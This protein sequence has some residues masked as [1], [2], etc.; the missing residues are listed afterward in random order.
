MTEIAEQPKRRGRKPKGDR[1]MTN[2]ERVAASRFRRRYPDKG[3]SGKQLSVMLSGRA[4]MALNDLMAHYGEGT[5]Q[6]EV[7]EAALLFYAA[8]CIPSRD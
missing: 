3:Y 1:S 8:H 7:V 6:R 4:H 2:A 5:I